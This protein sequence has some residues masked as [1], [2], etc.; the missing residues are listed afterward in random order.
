MSFLVLC[1]QQNA[2][3]VKI[4]HEGRHLCFLQKCKKLKKQ[5]QSTFHN[6]TLRQNT[7]MGEDFTLHAYTEG[8]QSTVNPGKN[9][10]ERWKNVLVSSVHLFIANKQAPQSRGKFHMAQ[11]ALKR[12]RILWSDTSVVNEAGPPAAILQRGLWSWYLHGQVDT[13]SALWHSSNST[14]DLH[15][16][17]S[18]LSSL[19]GDQ[20]CE[21]KGGGCAFSTFLCAHVHGYTGVFNARKFEKIAP[22]ILFQAKL[23]YG[24]AEQ[25][26]AIISLRSF[27]PALKLWF[28]VLLCCW[29]EFLY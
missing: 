19:R 18:Q 25:F 1:H 23:Q 6:Y 27:F 24:W 22:K 4:R 11:T 10:K 14:Q 7:F 28:V 2:S 5:I 13:L 21:R 29:H 20:F 12:A 3:G 8:L 16:F 26:A 9:T 15:I 17:S